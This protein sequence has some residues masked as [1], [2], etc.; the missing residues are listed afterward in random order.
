M[1]TWSSYRNDSPRPRS[2]ARSIAAT[3]LALLKLWCTWLLQSV[4]RAEKVAE[5][6]LV[7]WL[8]HS[9]T[10][11]LKGGH[12]FCSAFAGRM[13]RVF[14]FFLVSCHIF[15]FARVKGMASHPF[16][17]LPPGSVPGPS[18]GKGRWLEVGEDLA[19]SP[20]LKKTSA[21]FTLYEAILNCRGN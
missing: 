20:R 14:F 13:I 12:C 1:D 7:W 9:C 18:I 21:W 8:I 5:S 10:F 16:N 2:S 17:P 11:I 3:C 19:S 6:S 4:N 15:Y